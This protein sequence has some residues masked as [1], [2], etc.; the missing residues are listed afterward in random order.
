MRTQ[1]F[2][3]LLAGI[4]CSELLVTKE[5]TDY[6]KL[7]ATWEVVDYEENVFRGWTMEDAQVLLGAKQPDYQE[8]LPEFISTTPNP[9]SFS[10]FGANCIHEVKNQ[11]NCGSC[12]A[13]GVAGMVSD[14]CCMAKEDK[15][16]L[17]PQEL[18]SCDK[19]NWGCSGGWPLTAV[20]YVAN[21]QG[22]VLDTCFTYKAANVACATKCTGTGDWVHHCNCQQPE[23]CLGVENMKGCLRKG[24]ITVTFGVCRSF[25]NYRNGVYHC[26]CGGA[27]A[28]LHAVTAVGFGDEPECFWHVRNSW[29]AAWGDKG[30][31]KIGCTE[32]GMDGKYPNGNVRCTIA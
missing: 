3:L 26:D 31:F 12:W 4:F 1:I 28:G 32:C 9:S 7:H 14:L 6:L 24:P 5:Y 11:G 10:W 22:L 21:H 16:W 23:Q 17:A 8:L 2:A 25:F 15:G 20:Q 13:F 19:S 29:G 30:Y 27:Y 18:V